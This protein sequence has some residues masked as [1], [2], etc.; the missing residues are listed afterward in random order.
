MRK[1]RCRHE[2][3]PGELD[4]EYLQQIDPDDLEEMDLRWNIAMLTMRAKRFLKNTRRKL[5]MTNKERIGFDMSKG[6]MFST[7]KRKG[8][9]TLC[10]GNT[11]HTMNQIQQ[12]Q[13]P[14]RRLLPIKETTLNWHVNPLK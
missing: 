1:I 11:M 14:I 8:A 5:D 13:R 6:R 12:E 4:N 10:K 2:S 7:V 3:I 9:E